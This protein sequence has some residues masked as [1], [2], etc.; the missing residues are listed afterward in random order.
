MT[1]NAAGVLVTVPGLLDPADAGV[2]DAHNH[3]WIRQ[4]D[5]AAPNSPV[6]EDQPRIEAAIEVHTEGGADRDRIVDRLVGFGLA[7]SRLVLCHV[8]KR[9]DIGLLSQIRPRLQQ[10]GFPAETI[11]GLIGKNIAQRLARVR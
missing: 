1:E 11:S 2:T 10:E 9:P 6:L 5:G 8:D 4:V 3:T 7:R